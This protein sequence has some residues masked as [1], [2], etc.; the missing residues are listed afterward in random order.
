MHLS[1]A[2]SCPSPLPPALRQ[3]HLDPLSALSHVK[4]LHL[5]MAFVLNPGT[6][7]FLLGRHFPRL[8]GYT[9]RDVELLSPF[10]EKVFY[11]LMRESG[12]MHIQCTKPDTVGECGAGSQASRSAWCGP[13]GLT[14]PATLLRD[15]NLPGGTRTL[16]HAAVLGTG[17][18]LHGR[19][20]P[21]TCLS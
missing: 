17:Q 5:N 2:A 14:H 12:Y 9:Q 15:E 13:G 11:S 7:T 16:C 20:I 4:G 6:L 1:P 19:H 21:D 8:F 3:P 18:A 10:K